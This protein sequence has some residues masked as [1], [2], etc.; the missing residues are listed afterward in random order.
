MK[1]KWRTF[2]D[3][4]KGKE[5]LAISS[6][7]TLKSFW[8]T[9]KFM[10]F[11]MTIQKQLAN[12]KGCVGY[13]MIMEPFGKKYGTLSVWENED[14]LNKFTKESPHSKAMEDMKPCIEG[15]AKYARWKVQGREIPP[16][17]DD[18]FNRF[19]K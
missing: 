9:P 15:K 4:E 19:Q 2:A 18:G 11:G 5:Y 3:I 17:W 8:D 6:Y 13:L 1:T 14:F 7:L 16:S 12:T 10:K